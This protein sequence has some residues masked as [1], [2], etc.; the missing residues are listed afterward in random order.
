M[1]SRLGLLSFIH[2][3]NVYPAPTLGQA[4]FSAFGAPQ[5]TGLT[6]PQPWWDRRV[7]TGGGERQG[8]RP[9][10]VKL[11]NRRL[12]KKWGSDQC[13]REKDNFKGSEAQVGQLQD[14]GLGSSRAVSK[15]QGS[16]LPFPS[17]GSHASLLGSQP[18]WTEA[19]LFTC[20]VQVTPKSHCPHCQSVP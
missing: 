12:R 3:S 13:C 2:S 14:P 9:R 17:T 4:L 19:K 20:S 11:V 18:R 5:P 8:D 15:P 16:S 10:A 7:L 1:K 6:K